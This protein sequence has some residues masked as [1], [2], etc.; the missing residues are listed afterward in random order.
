MALGS[1]SEPRGT[2]FLDIT[3]CLLHERSMQTRGTSAV[4]CM[5]VQRISQQFRCPDGA[6]RCQQRLTI[7]NVRHD[8]AALT[9]PKTKHSVVRYSGLPGTLARARKGTFRRRFVRR[10]ILMFRR[11]MS[12]GT[13][14][15][16]GACGQALN[17]PE[18]SKPRSAP[19]QGESSGL[20]L[21]MGQDAPAVLR[22]VRTDV[23][24]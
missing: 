10:I 14:A 3:F 23:K 4:Q 18:G 8:Q 19:R 15:R 1:S 22:D 20:R 17:K 11:V 21:L 12:A 6:G 13:G 2:R 5:R 9:K 16:D 24:I 7:C